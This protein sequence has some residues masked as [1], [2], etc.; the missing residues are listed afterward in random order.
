MFMFSKFLILPCIWKK[1]K[2]PFFFPFE[3]RDHKNGG[4]PTVQEKVT[5]NH[6]CEP[7]MQFKI[8]SSLIKN[9][10]SKG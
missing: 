6:E 8:F 10:K 2:K 3:P 7:C 9:M 4:H 1:K 5:L